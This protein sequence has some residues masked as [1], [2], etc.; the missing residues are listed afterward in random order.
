MET[1]MLLPLT[2]A[3]VTK[4][5]DDKDFTDTNY[6]HQFFCKQ[7]RDQEQELKELLETLERRRKQQQQQQQQQ[8]QLY[9]QWQ[10]LF[11]PND[12]CKFS[13]FNVRIFIAEN[14][15]YFRNFQFLNSHSRSKS[16]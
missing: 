8:Q 11:T 6:Y 10:L 4:V 9:Q 3:V 5:H 16:Y 2:P 1:T 14:F 13:F 15:I 7:L 12:S